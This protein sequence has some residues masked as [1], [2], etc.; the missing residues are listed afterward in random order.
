M[1]WH[2]STNENL[3]RTVIQVRAPMATLFMAV[4]V[5]TFLY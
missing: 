4:V 5:V 2:G 3:A 1:T